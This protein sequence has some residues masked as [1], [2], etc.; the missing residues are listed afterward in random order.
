MPEVLSLDPGVTTGWA[1]WS[2]GSLLG[3]G[4]YDEVATGN[5]IDHFTKTGG[6]VVC[7]A[8]IITAETLRRSRQTAS[9]EL[10]GVAK[11]FARTR[12]CTFVMQTASSAKKFCTDD[13]L[14][15][16]GW[17]QRGLGH[18]DDALRHLC[19]YLVKNKLMEV[20]RGNG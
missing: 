9:L 2:C 5:L 13:R 12:D 20:P 3:A 16:A 7:E 10:I 11:H 1:L 8:Y 19:T 17:K 6:V 15:A 4:E 14:R 18:A